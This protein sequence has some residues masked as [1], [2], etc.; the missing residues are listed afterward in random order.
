MASQT[1][2]KTQ[3]TAYSEGFKAGVWVG[4]ITVAIMFFLLMYFFPLPHPNY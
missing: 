1:I 4:G 3:K 2:T